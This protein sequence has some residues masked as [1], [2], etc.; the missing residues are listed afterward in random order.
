[1]RKSLASLGPRVTASR[2]VADYV[3]RLY[4]PTA[5]RTDALAADGLARARVLAAWKQR[6]AAAWHGVHVDRVDGDMAAVELGASRD[7]EA[8]V[9]LGSLSA[10]DVDVQLVHGPV[11]QGDELT[12]RTCVSMRP[13]GPADDDH[14]RYVGSLECSRAGRYGLTVRI[15][16]RHAD[17]VDN[18]EL[19]LAAWA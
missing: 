10:D 19:G 4:E 17:L 11:G 7:V 14:A 12:E 16:P 15:V 2:M 1:V 13:A 8:V 18:S 5:A 6:V 9:S 3:Q